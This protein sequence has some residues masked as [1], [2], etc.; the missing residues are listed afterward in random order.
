MLGQCGRTVAG[1]A[2]GGVCACYR[3]SSCCSAGGC[4]SDAVAAEMLFFDGS[5]VVFIDSNFA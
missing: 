1:V 2:E 5:E 3:S 4:G